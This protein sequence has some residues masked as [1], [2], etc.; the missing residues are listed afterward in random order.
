MVRASHIGEW[1]SDLRTA[2]TCRARKSKACAALH[3]DAQIHTVEGGEGG[4]SRVTERGGGH[5][6]AAD[7]DVQ[8][9]GEAR[10]LS[11]AI[12]GLRQA[13]DQG[14]NSS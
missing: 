14:S 10:G 12:R 9:R 6:A 1:P 2:M 11:E 8:P 13:E 5:G 3:G 4:P 7:T